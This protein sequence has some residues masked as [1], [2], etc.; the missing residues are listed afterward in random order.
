MSYGFSMGFAQA[1]DFSEAM[2]LAQE[3]VDERMKLMRK[4]GEK[5]SPSR[6]CVNALESCFQGAAMYKASYHRV[7]VPYCRIRIPA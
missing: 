3:Y 2:S 1:K 5:L 6:H 4:S 7:I